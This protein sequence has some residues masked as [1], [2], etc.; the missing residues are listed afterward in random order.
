MKILLS[1]MA[2]MV[3][4]VCAQDMTEEKPDIVLGSNGKPLSAGQLKQKNLSEGYYPTLEAREK[5]VYEASIAEPERITGWRPMHHWVLQLYFR[6]GKIK[7]ANAI[8]RKYMTEQLEVGRKRLENALKNGTYEKHTEPGYNGFIMWSLMNVYIN[9]EKQVEPDVKAMI[10]KMLTENKSHKGTT[11]NLSMIHTLVLY[12]AE[13]CWDPAL[14]AK[15][16][17]RGASGA[18]AI[19]WLE[20]RIEYIA[21]NGSG[22]FASRPYMLY[23]I[24]TLLSLDNSFTDKKLAEKA[25]MAYEMSLAHAAGTWLNGNW[26]TPAGRSYPDQLDMRTAPMLWFYFGGVTPELNSERTAIFSMAEKFRPSPLIV[27]AATN[28]AK[29]YLHRSRFDGDKVYQTSYVNKTYALFCSASDPKNQVWGQCY[30]Y[31]VMFDQTNVN[32]CSFLWMTAPL[33]D[34]KPCSSYTH[35]V[36]S[37]VCQYTQNKGAW[38]F[39][40]KNLDD[41]KN[42]PKDKVDEK[43]KLIE[44]V[45]PANKGRLP[46]LAF[47]PGGHTALI[48]EANTTGCV[49]L[50]YGSVLVALR[51]TDKFEYNPQGGIYCGARDK[52][53]SEFRVYGKHLAGVMDT[54]L[55]ADYPGVTAQAQLE[56]FKRDIEAKTKLTLKVEG[57]TISA[58]YKDRF[59]ETLEKIHD[60]EAKINGQ[61]LDYKS[62]PL[63]DNPWVHQGFGGK[64]M[65]VTDGTTTCVYDLSNWTITE[66]KAP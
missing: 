38:L 43:G 65:T 29:A 17:R 56:A 1:I 45:Y 7:E 26:A 20:K 28:R 15:D 33:S 22:E 47:I 27:N 50:N 66:Q 9:W 39:V 42:L 25:R 51:M 16:A 23:N 30:P 63:V 64:N 8:L 36:N 57:E 55:P 53:A 48:N 31:G 41:P 35:G 32:H 12:L 2:M 3:C 4:C 5:A 58:S 46:I 49:Y 60:G 13:K 59:N 19:P 11:G 18:Q 34:H 14:F 10:Q 24:G 6:Q 61:V 62:W 54:A 37:R 52:G 44:A 40:A 21:K